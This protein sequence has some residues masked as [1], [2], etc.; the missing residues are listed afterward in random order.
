V[1]AQQSDDREVTEHLV[2]GTGTVLAGNGHGIL[3]ALGSSQLLANLRALN[4]GVKH[5]QD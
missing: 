5:I 2:E 1:H 4:E 3:S